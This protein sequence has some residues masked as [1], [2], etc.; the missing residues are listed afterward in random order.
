MSG[1]GDH[2][3]SSGGDAV[4]RKT[5]LQQLPQSVSYDVGYKKPPATTQF[6]KGQ[7]G[8]P[9]GAAQGIEEQETCNE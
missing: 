6:K 3:A 4:K 1:P 9:R 2:T 7:S 5:S 8:N